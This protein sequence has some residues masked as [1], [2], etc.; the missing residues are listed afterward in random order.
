[1]EGMLVVLGNTFGLSVVSITGSHHCVI[2]SFSTEILVLN[3][4]ALVGFSE[5]PQLATR[6]SQLAPRS[7]QLAARSSQLAAR[8]SQL[9]ARATQSHENE[10]K[11]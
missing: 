9:A 5:R 1:M 7:S 2:F 8:S 4:R 3:L 6:N 10:F 11:K